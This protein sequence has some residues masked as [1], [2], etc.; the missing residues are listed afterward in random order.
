MDTYELPVV[1]DDGQRRRFTIVADTIR[2]ESEFEVYLKDDGILI[3]YEF[4]TSRAH[5]LSRKEQLREWLGDDA[6]SA[7]MVKIDE[8]MEARRQPPSAN[9]C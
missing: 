9:P 6:Y 1:D 5:P 7:A 4:N 8:A 3:V 2:K